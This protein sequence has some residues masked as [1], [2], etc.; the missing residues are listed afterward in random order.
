MGEASTYF[1][2]FRVGIFE[3]AKFRYFRSGVVEYLLLGKED[4]QMVKY[5][6]FLF[7]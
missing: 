4:V 5:I 1:K 7:N 2:I 3:L 6:K